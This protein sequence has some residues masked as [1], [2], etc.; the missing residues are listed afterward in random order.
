MGLVVSTGQELSELV[1]QECNALLGA[2]V[3]TLCSSDARAAGLLAA[4]AT[5]AGIA[6]A[7]IAAVWTRAELTILTAGCWGAALVALA[8][9]GAALWAVWP[10]EMLLPGWA[11]SDFENDTDKTPEEIVAEMLLVN[12]TKIDANRGVLEK[13]HRRS[14]LSVI[15]LAYTP[16]SAFAGALCTFGSMAIGGA[17]LIWSGLAVILFMFFVPKRF[18]TPA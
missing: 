2:Q 15:L 5:I 14:L 16:L 17:L 10:I 11:P 1:N 18:R 9:A 12:Q 3:A 4:S 6:F 8:A 13:M 7:A